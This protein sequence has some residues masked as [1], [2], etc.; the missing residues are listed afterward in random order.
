MTP[1][2]EEASLPGAAVLQLRSKSAPS[3]QRGG[4]ALKNMA[5]SARRIAIGAMITGEV[6]PTIPY[7]L[8]IV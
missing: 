4:S 2:D 8:K 5:V 7:P 6:L 1:T 3:A